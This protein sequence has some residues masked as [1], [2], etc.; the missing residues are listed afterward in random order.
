VIVEHDI[1]CPALYERTRLELLDLV[2]SLTHQQR[3]HVVPATPAWSVQDVVAHVTGIAADLNANRFSDDQDAWTAAQ[4]D[5]R[6][7]RSVRELRTEWDAE[8]PA[9]EEGLRLFGYEMAAHFLGDLLQHVADVRHALGLERIADDHA[10]TAALDFY[11]DSFHE[12]LV[13]AEVGSVAVH[14]GGDRWALGT[15]DEVATWS[16]SR[17]EVLRALGGRRD[18]RQIRGY[19]WTGEV[20]AIVPLVSRY[21]VPPTG[22]VEP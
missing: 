17:Y 10:L 20:D 19:E 2:E 21:G 5:A 3:S 8:A 15:G 13:E 11:L 1:D 7:G 4:V 9:F 14:V 18:E 6:R 16:A 12:S 22:L